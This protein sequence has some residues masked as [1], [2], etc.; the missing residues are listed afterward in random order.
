MDGLQ[1]AQLLY[2]SRGNEKQMGGVLLINLREYQQ[3]LY[4]KTVKQ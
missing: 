3:D 2:Q 4:D 1:K